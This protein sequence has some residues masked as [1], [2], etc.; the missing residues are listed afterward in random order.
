MTCTP[1][2][3]RR[4]IWADKQRKAEEERKRVKAVAIALALAAVDTGARI[5]GASNDRSNDADDP[6]NRDGA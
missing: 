6:A 1:C 3:R 2:E 5:I 4:K